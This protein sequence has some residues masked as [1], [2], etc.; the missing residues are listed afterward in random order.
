MDSRSPDRIAFHYE[1]EKELAA[2]L[3]L[4]TRAE[5]TTMY[6]AIYNELFHRVADHP[7]WQQK[8]DEAQSQAQALRQLRFIKRFLTP[9]AVFMEVGAGDCALAL[10]VAKEVSTAFAIDVSKNIVA[11]AIPANLH[12]LIS[13]GIDVPLPPGSVDVAY[14]NQLME[15]LHP[16]DAREQLSNIKKVLAPGGIY[17]C[18][19]PNRL[20]GPH[21]ISRHYDDT[22]T[23]LHLKEYTITELAALFDEIG[24]VK[25]R[26]LLSWHSFVFP[27]LLAPAFFIRLEA[28]LASLPQGLRRI[29]SI[30]LG[31]AKM[32]TYKAAG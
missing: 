6:V 1:I 31:A 24:F 9:A 16:A 17:I 3:K 23:G 29:P 10:R 5:R 30:P 18:V 20:S 27:L 8:R 11:G 2:K 13:D 21:D 15:H 32:V 4:S 14:S 28:A 25:T 26:I 12:T 19:T 7:Q 22:A